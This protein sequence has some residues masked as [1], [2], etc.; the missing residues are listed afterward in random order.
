M[1]NSV[2]KQLAGMNDLL[3]GTGQAIQ[4]RAGS[5]LNIDK[6]NFAY[7]F[8]S[9]A[10]FISST[11]LSKRLG[12]TVLTGGTLWKIA[13]SG[14]LDIGNGLHA[15]PLSSINLQDYSVKG[16]Y[17]KILNTGTDNV[18]LINNSIANGGNYKLTSGNYLTSG[19]IVL[20]SNTILSFDNNCNLYPPSSSL[21]D[22]IKIEGVGP[23]E[24]AFV[25][26]DANAD[27]TATSIT[28]SALTNVS[29]GDYIEL[30]SNKLITGVNNKNTRQALMRKVIN[31][32]QDTYYFNKPLDYDLN[33][34]ESAKVAKIPLVKQ[35]ITLDAANLNDEN[36]N[37]LINRG[38]V[39]KYCDNLTIISPKIY[40]SKQKNGEDISG[41]TG[42]LINNCHNVKIY[43]AV[44]KNLGWYGIGVSGFSEEIYIVDLLG[45]DT[46]HTFDITHATLQNT[47]EGEPN[48]VYLIRCKSRN[49][50]SS[51]I[52]THDTGKNVI[53]FSPVSIGSGKSSTTNGYGIYI[54]NKETV[55]INPIAEFASLDG[56]KFETG[57]YGCSVINARTNFNGVILAQD[58]INAIG[59]Y[60]IVDGLH[61]EGNGSAGLSVREGKFNNIRSI[62]NNSYAFRFFGGGNNT[63]EITNSYAP[64]TARQTV[65]YRA[66]TNP[67][68]LGT[69]F[70]PK[71]KLIL[72]NNVTTGYGNF[73]FSV[74]EN[75]TE[76]HWPNTD[77]SNTIHVSTGSGDKITEELTLSAGEA[78]FN[79]TS[80]R[81]YH[82]PFGIENATPGSIMSKI[83]IDPI[84]C[85]DHEAFNYIITDETSVKIT[86][87]D[88]SSTAQLRIT[89][90]W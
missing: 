40:G 62:D 75:S 74:S 49:D 7:S 65:C 85:S 71:D 83:K 57:A 4:S 87:T 9:I 67:P 61:A 28:S 30:R 47:N 60:V 72:R 81:N 51:G 69:N 18:N 14:T 33:T 26:I 24:S 1:V 53:L 86:S 64:R 39:A 17:N 11:G 80:V 37:Y 56:I 78:I 73:L 3:L 22:M 50:N 55:L 58:G 5:D 70:K 25:N 32:V 63:I 15:N 52:S 76:K 68:P 27:K 36:Y 77:G 23:Q 35:N 48:G 20:N 2:I 43:N 41:R 45:E 10:D 88:T 38:I 90:G 13:S 54:R 31:K 44:T 19:S 6:I 34:S 66:E 89:I 21:I 46:R 12:E 79:T 29:I 42:I 59:E 16:D 84:V 8:N 82:P